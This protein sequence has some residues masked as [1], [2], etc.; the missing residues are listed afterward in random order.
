MLE[1]VFLRLRIRPMEDTIQNEPSNKTFNFR[2]LFCL[3][4]IFYGWFEINRIEIMIWGISKFSFI[5]WN[6]LISDK[7][8]K[9]FF[10]L[11]LLNTSH[12]FT[13]TIH[14]PKPK[15]ILLIL[16]F[17][18]NISLNAKRSIRPFQNRSVITL[19]VSWLVRIFFLFFL[20]AVGGKFI[21]QIK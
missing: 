14:N 1:W 8:K 19:F 12:T 6:T 17:L 11:D 9:I 21:L 15:S 20:N 18:K 7:K 4:L 10:L 16:F 13:V 3:V 2:Q 5:I